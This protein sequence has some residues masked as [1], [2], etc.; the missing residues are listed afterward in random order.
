[1]RNFIHFSKTADQKKRD[2]QGDT[3]FKVA[4]VLDELMKGMRKAWVAGDKVTA[5]ESMIR[6]MGRA[7]SFVQYMPCQPIKH[8]LKV[9]A[10]CSA[11]T[12]VC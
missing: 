5:D 11:Y 3:P 8:G 9:F 2:E 12:S 7:V 10:V 4:H 1:M 6:Y